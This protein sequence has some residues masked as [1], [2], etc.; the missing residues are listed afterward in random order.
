MKKIFLLLLLMLSVFELLA[1]VHV[2]GY[3]RKNGTYVQS[4][5]RSSPD[6]NPYNNWSYPGNT[7]PYT[8]K[9]ATGNP[10]TYL[11]NYHNRDKDGT[12]SV[13]SSRAIP[14]YATPTYS[15]RNSFPSSNAVETTNRSSKRVHTRKAESSLYTDYGPDSKY[16]RE[17][18]KNYGPNSKYARDL[19]RNYGPNS[20]YA[21]DLEKNY[22]PNSQYARDLEKNY[23]PNSKYA[24]DLQKRYN[25]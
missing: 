9:V 23:G 13:T 4:H 19:E 18:E 21:R 25:Y 20:K 3:Y 1:Q 22:G 12:S 6:G 5:Y 11:N 2:R 8:G 15:D 24:R 16:V 17:L 10:E 7:N 14:T